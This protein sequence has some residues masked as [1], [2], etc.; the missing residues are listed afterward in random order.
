MTKQQAQKELNELKAR[1]TELLEIIN[2]PE[3]TPEQKFLQLIDGLTIKIDKENYP[4]SIFYLRKDKYII[5]VKNDKVILNRYLFW[6][7]FK[8]EFDMHYF[9]IQQFIESML[10]KYFKMNEVEASSGG[11]W[12]DS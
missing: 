1:E 10:K 6:D 9:Q 8:N 11:M 5:E 4:N 12:P 2:A 3:I 7:I